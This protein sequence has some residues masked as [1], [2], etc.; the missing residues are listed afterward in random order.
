MEQTIATTRHKLDFP[1]LVEALKEQ[2][3]AK[4]DLVLPAKSLTMTDDASLTFPSLD[5]IA[6][7]QIEGVVMPQASQDEASG[8]VSD[9]AHTQIAERCQIPR[10]Y[11][12]RMLQDA[13]PLLA[14]NVNHW[15]G[16]D[17]RNVFLRTF[18]TGDGSF[19]RAMLSDR[20]RVVDNLDVMYAILEEL[21]A[22]K[23]D[24]RFSYCDVSE[25]RMHMRLEFP[26]MQEDLNK[27]I[28][29]DGS[30]DWHQPEGPDPWFGGMIVSNSETG[31]GSVSIKPR[32]VRQ[33]CS[34]G[35]IVAHSVLK[36][37][38]LGGKLNE[39]FYEG[40]KTR[41]LENDLLFSRIK[42]LVKQLTDRELFRDFLR[43]FT[44]SM[45]NALENPIRATENV[46]NY[47]GLTEERKESL[48]DRF[49]KLEARTQFGVA[50]AVTWLAHE[51]E[52]EDAEMAV[53]L[54]TAGGNFL[55]MDAKDFRTQFETN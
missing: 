51:Y 55:T 4:S 32:L 25:T 9:I 2:Q 41:K 22:A 37:F 45:K 31:N 28:L 7:P 48:L 27:L 30:H 36:Q 16:R 50:D 17:D 23:I 21:D 39:G 5:S 3:A 44:G 18:S 42:D 14:E 1:A 8:S 53:A 43:S 15:L 35:A 19:V 34:N 12:T 47:L 10:A 29:R 33:I 54:E 6:L 46:A 11:Y 40:D 13:R 38:H 52:A 49:F 24:V 26:D 20:Y